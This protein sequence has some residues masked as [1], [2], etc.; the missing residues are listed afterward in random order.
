M[1]IKKLIANL[2]KHKLFTQRKNENNRNRNIFV[3][4]KYFIIFI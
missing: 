1:E 3:I 4:K 2:N